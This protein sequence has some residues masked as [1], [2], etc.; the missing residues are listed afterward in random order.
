MAEGSPDGAVTKVLGP[1]IG[2]AIGGLITWLTAGSAGAL[3]HALTTA[4]TLLGAVAGVIFSV[5]YRRYVGILAAGAG[6]RESL[7]RKAYDS[8]RD[9]LAQ[10]R[11]NSAQLHPVAQPLP[12]LGR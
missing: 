11:G 5:L 4:L 6:D 10:G 1:P 7:E 2:A 8:L 9:S 3:S 12:R